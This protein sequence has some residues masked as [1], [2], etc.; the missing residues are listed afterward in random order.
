MVNWG[1]VR[2]VFLDMDG[3]LLDLHYDNHFWRE[4]VPSKYAQLRGIEEDAAQAAVFA[5]YHRHA[6]TLNWYC[7]DFWSAELELDIARL[8]EEVAHLIAVHPHVP[9]FLRETKAA[10]KRVV[11]VTN[12][13]HKSLTLKLQRTGLEPHF[14]AVIS[15]HALGLPKED[16]AF[17]SRLQT[18]EAFEPGSTLLVDDSLPVLRAARDYGIA[19]L[20]SV[21]KPDSRQPERTAEEFPHLDSFRDLLPVS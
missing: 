13:H 8:K 7:V 3:T 15:A 9:E 16:R 6:G 5:R 20:V 10:D 21:K 17:W 19:Q 2:T 18:V 1:M 11:L 4:Y 12:A 14:D